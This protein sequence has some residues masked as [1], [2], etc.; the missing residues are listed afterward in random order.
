MLEPSENHD[1]KYWVQRLPTSRI[2]LVKHFVMAMKPVGAVM[3]P[4]FIFVA[5]L[6]FETFGECTTGCFNWV[7]QQCMKKAEIFCRSR[8]MFGGR[9][10]RRRAKILTL[11]YGVA[12][13]LMLLLG[14]A[15]RPWYTAARSCKVEERYW[16]WDCKLW[17]G[18]F[19]LAASQWRSSHFPGY[20]GTH[21]LHFSHTKHD[22]VE[23]TK[24]SERTNIATLLQLMMRLAGVD[25]LII[26]SGRYALLGT[27]GTIL[28]CTSLYCL[29][30]TWLRVSSS[31][32][33][34]NLN[35]RFD[36]AKEGKDQSVTEIFL[37][38]NNIFM[39]LRQPF[40]TKL[41]PIFVGQLL[42]SATYASSIHDDLYQ[43][44]CTGEWSWYKLF[45]GVVVQFLLITQLGKSFVLELEDWVFLSR[46]TE[47]VV[48]DSHE[49]HY[50]GVRCLM[51]FIVNHIVWNFLIC[52]VPLNMVGTTD[53][54][55]FVKDCLAIGYITML[56]DVSED[57]TK[58]KVKL[59][60]RKAEMELEEK[61]KHLF[62]GLRIGSTEQKPQG[63]QTKKLDCQSLT[64]DAAKR[65][66]L[67]LSRCS[68]ISWVSEPTE[69]K[70]QYTFWTDLPD[71]ADGL[72]LLCVRKKQPTNASSSNDLEEGLLDSTNQS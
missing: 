15:L 37:Y 54:M 71:Q 67:S 48:S 8:W 20:A 62:E 36:Q 3:I 63:E 25:I 69:G 9:H 33:V 42:L 38:P 45:A 65:H 2:E 59:D 19:L 22:P 18:F 14:K 30:T 35:L 21:E 43:V 4:F 49:D 32:F 5:L 34:R 53:G 72:E 44:L 61:C 28:V 12:L 60:T 58:I 52:T 1:P 23:V 13:F 7:V 10:T 31:A 40:S 46:R 55:D 57:D 27:L 39:D 64:H 26:D 47:S 29:G 6:H 66:A 68:F 41:M 11:V 50:V 24:R 56:D 51:S 16:Y 70:R 17:L